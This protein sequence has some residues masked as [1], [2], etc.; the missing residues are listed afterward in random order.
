MINFR[1]T[2]GTHQVPYRGEK[3][4]N[5]GKVSEVHP[6]H[7]ASRSGYTIWATVKPLTYA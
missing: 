1:S 4:K 7:R 6:K 3:I 2:I 5:D